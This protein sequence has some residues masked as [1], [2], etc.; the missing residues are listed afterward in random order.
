MAANS[1]RSAPELAALIPDFVYQPGRPA[2]HVLPREAFVDSDPG[3]ILT[4]AAFVD[5][6]QPLPPWLVFDPD[7]LRFSA[8]N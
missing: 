4:L 1:S 7:E 6:G 8:Q 2:E 3:D 5:G